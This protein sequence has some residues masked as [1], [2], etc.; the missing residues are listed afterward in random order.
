MTD[1]NGD[2]KVLSYG[3]N[4]LRRSDVDLLD[5]PFWLND[6]I[7][8]FYF[9]YLWREVYA[10][11]QS[12]V[13]FVGGAM[14]FLLSQLAGTGDI[15]GIVAP[16]QLSSRSLICFAV[17]DNPDAGNAEGG[18]HW[19]LA[20][21]SKKDKTFFH[22]DS[23]SGSCNVLAARTVA[24]AVQ[25]YLEGP[26]KKSKVVAVQAPMQ[27]N[28]Y[29]CGVYVLACADMIVQA[30]TKKHSQKQLEEDLQRQLTPRAVIHVRAT[31]LSIVQ[32]KMA[33]A[34]S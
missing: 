5:G 11:H 23:A 29:D 19:T 22:Y 14:T 25:P 18:S 1:R 28:A 33:Q 8:T 13:L 24:R 15:S 26:S 9:D 17:N 2:E 7:I 20:V 4:L 10:A 21:Y 6:Q 3:D 12:S 16:L 32:A 27:T 31:I 30:W 34:N